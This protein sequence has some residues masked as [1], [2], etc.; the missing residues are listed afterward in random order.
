MRIRTIKPAFWKSESMASICP[1]SRLAAIALLNFADDEG[2][3]VCSIPVIRGEL[4]PFEEDSTNVRRAIDDLSRIG[5]LVTGKTE[6]GKV[7]GRITNFLEHQRIDR[8]QASE[9]AGL[10]VIW[11]DS[12]NIRRTIDESSLLEAEGKRK[13][14]RNGQGSGTEEI[15]SIYQAY[16]RKVAKIPALKA[17]ER[18][19]RKVSAESLLESTRSFARSCVGKDPQY[20]PHPATWFNAGRWEDEGICSVP[21][22]PL[23]FYKGDLDGIDPEALARL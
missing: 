5:F 19:L 1:F 14:K 16:P 12:T 23:A 21:S 17:I 18:A 20:I 8:A 6:E 4:F 9:I 11:N 7:F 15:E 2:Y 22:I 13:G 10:D 3:F